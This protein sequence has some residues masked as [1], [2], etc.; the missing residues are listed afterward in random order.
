MTLFKL[1]S[2]YLGANVIMCLVPFGSMY[3]S[4]NW[5]SIPFVSIE[6]IFVYMLT[7]PIL[8]NTV[9]Y[10]IFKSNKYLLLLSFAFMVSS[11]VFFIYCTIQMFGYAVE[12]FRPF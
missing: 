7:L 1:F 3:Y 5:I 11:Y 8:L 6:P 2:I 10:F 12:H 9:F 4:V